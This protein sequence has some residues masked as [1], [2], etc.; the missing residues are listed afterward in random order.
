MRNLNV[1]V[2]ST[3]RMEVGTRGMMRHSHGGANHVAG[4]DKVRQRP[5][6]KARSHATPHRTVSRRRERRDSKR[7]TTPRRLACMTA[8]RVPP[9]A[10]LPVHGGPQIVQAP[11][12]HSERR[13]VSTLTNPV[14]SAPTLSPN[15]LSVV[16]ARYLRRNA[17]Q[18][19]DE[20]RNSSLI[21]SRGPSDSSTT[22][23][24]PAELCHQP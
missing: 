15:A 2:C 7:V 1:S 5:T 10:G 18:H 22:A 16:E 19:I 4:R 21:A 11:T 23:E 20:T 24:H 12:E 17:H 3:H 9:C 13:F 8:P 6:V 14:M